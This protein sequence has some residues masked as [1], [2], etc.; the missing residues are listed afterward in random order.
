MSDEEKTEEHDPHDE[1]LQHQMDTNGFTGHVALHQQ[2]EKR[3]HRAALTY[4]EHRVSG[5]H[6]NCGD[7]CIHENTL[8]DAYR[9]MMST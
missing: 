4:C 3:F 8:L 9:L 7:E 2:A 5:A 6:I 1:H